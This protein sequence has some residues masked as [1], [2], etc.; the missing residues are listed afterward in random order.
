MYVNIGKLRMPASYEGRTA[1]SPASCQFPCWQ[2]YESFLV[3]GLIRLHWEGQEMHRTIAHCQE[4][5]QRRTSQQ[6]WCRTSISQLAQCFGIAAR[7]KCKST[8]WCSWWTCAT[9]SLLN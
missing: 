5:W 8:V 9:K 1:E 4:P 6:T 3:R 2:W 7:K